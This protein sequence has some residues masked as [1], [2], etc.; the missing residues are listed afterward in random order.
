M[1]INKCA[2]PED[3]IGGTF[4]FP[5]RTSGD[6]GQEFVLLSELGVSPSHA[7][8]GWIQTNESCRPGYEKANPVVR[9]AKIKVIL[10]EEVE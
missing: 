8:V 1:K 7:E 4:W 2:I 3:L 5:V 6:D 10:V 9:I